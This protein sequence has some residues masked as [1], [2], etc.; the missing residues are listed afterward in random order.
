MLIYADR[1]K[2]LELAKN[3]YGVCHTMISIYDA[4][5]KPI[6][7][8]PD[9]MCDFCAEIRKSPTL[10]ARCIRCDEIALN[11]CQ[12]THKLYSYKCHMGLIETAVPIIS[13]DMV[14]GYI[15]FGQITDRKNKTPLLEGLEEVARKHNLS[16][17]TLKDGSEKIKYRSPRYISSI[18]K[19]TEMCASFIWQNSFIRIQKDTTAQA[20]DLFLRENLALDL[21]VPLLCRQFG[22]SRSSLYSLSRE[23]FGCGVSEYIA[24]LRIEAAKTLLS[25]GSSVGHTAE[26]VGVKDVNYFIRMFKAREGITPKQFSKNNLAG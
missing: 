23:H 11:K 1:E 18:S 2:L 3:F 10:T 22:I 4:N 9:K 6:C 8:Y 16:Y 7:S 17:Q 20:L 25:E 15:L 21:S 12:E 19:L 5:K 13:N 14:I 24:R 26:A